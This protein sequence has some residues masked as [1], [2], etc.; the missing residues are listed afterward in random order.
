MRS[1][2]STSTREVLER[3]L[4]ENPGLTKPFPH[5]VDGCTWSTQHK[6]ENLRTGSPLRKVTMKAKRQ[7]DRSS[8]DYASDIH[9]DAEKT[10]RST[11]GETEGDEAEMD[12]ELRRNIKVKLQSTAGSGTSRMRSDT[13]T[14]TAP[15]QRRHQRRLCGNCTHRCSRSQDQSSSL[16]TLGNWMISR[17]GR[18]R[19]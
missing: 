16:L 2:Q 14:P 15:S 17:R 11:V 8:R 3:M 5:F 13:M 19:L 4:E 9:E 10:E 7:S 1:N 6:M 12:D 18:K